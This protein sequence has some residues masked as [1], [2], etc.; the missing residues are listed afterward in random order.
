MD[1]NLQAF[2]TTIAV[3]EGTYNQGRRNGYD[4]LVG[5]TPSRVRRFNDFDR[6]PNCTMQV[7]DEIWSS[8]AGRYQ[9]IYPTW[10]GLQ[11]RLNLPDF[12][13]A[14][15]DRAAIEL[16]TDAAALELVQ[17]GDLRTAIEKCAKIWASFP[18]AGYGQRENTPAYLIA[19]YRKAGG[20][21]L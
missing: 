6:H 15:Q 10:V 12:S 3:S 1:S 20:K 8:A 18:G 14:S 19:A 7:T 13:P 4:I 2:L 9:I 16:I 11:K 21:L 5:S 17:K